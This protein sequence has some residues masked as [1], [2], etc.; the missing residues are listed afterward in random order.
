MAV[1]AASGIA[2][3][4]CSLCY[5]RQAY[6]FSLSYGLAMAG[7][8]G[9]VLLTS[10][11]SALVTAHAALV[12]A[13]GARL[14]AFLFWRQQFQPSYDG[15]AKLKALDKTPRLQRT[16]AVLSTGLFYGL[17]SSPLLF[18]LQAAPLAGLAARVSGVGCAVAALG[19]AYEAVA[20]QQKS[21]YKIGL[22]AAGK[23]D[24]LYVGGVW[25]AS[26]HANYFGELVFW[27]GS[28]V[29]GLPA[30][31]ATGVPLYVR[32]LKGLS[33]G[34]GLAGIFFI[35]L[36]A[37]K[38]LEGKYDDKYR[39]VGGVPTQRYDAYFASSNA[40]VPKVL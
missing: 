21:I 25:A 30:L 35:M 5:I 29:A 10:P 3:V 27:S 32:A 7:I 6:V 12:A 40:L 9:A 19:L 39:K 34:L 11:A 8:G 37:T 23:D 14:F 18:H 2:A 13:Y 38:R 28:F 33:S 31:V 24:E 1:P 16:P 17:M 36:S 15:M 26:R 20:D 22:R 4:A